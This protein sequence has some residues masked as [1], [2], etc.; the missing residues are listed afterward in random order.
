VVVN[1]F[2]LFP[3]GSP[4]TAGLL[5]MKTV[6]ALQLPLSGSHKRPKPTIS[7]QGHI[8]FNSLS[9]DH[10]QKRLRKLLLMPKSSFNSLSR[11]HKE[12]RGEVDT[13]DVTNFQL[14]LSGSPLDITS[15]EICMIFCVNF[16]LP[17]SGSLAYLSP[18]DNY[19]CRLQPFNSLS[20]DHA[21]IYKEPGVSKRVVDILSTPSL[22]ITN[23]FLL[24]HPIL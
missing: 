18:A 9:R 24:S 19:T 21:T 14:P 17:L 23:G 20:R 11:D 5:G 4:V 8:S 16:Q 7:A 12:M 13:F 15:V 2:Q 22:G 10:G 6:F 3:P 1:S